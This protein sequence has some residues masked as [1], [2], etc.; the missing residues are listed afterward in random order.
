MK[1]E[2]QGWCSRGTIAVVPINL[3]EKSDFL[4]QFFQQFWILNKVESFESSKADFVILIKNVTFW[5]LKFQNSFT[6]AKYVHPS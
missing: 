3:L 5:A 1:Y 4:A 2:Q 6:K